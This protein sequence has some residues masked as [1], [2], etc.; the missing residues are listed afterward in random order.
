[1][2]ESLKRTIIGVIAAIV[3]G[4]V[5]FGYFTPEQGEAAKEAT[6]GLIENIGTLIFGALSI[7]GIVTGGNKEKE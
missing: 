3:A 5:A 6:T 1:M 4:A 2:K 7:W